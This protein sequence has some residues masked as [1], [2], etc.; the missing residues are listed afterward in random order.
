MAVMEYVIGAL[1]GGLD[2]F[3]CILFHGAFLPQRNLGKRYVP[4]VLAIWIFCCV[5]TN[6]PMNQYVKMVLSVTVYT[7]LSV[8]LLQ[9]AVPVHICLAIVYNIFN[10]SMDTLAIHGMCYLLGISYNAFVWHKLSYITL[11]TAEKLLVVFLMWILY[12][13]RKK[14][15]LGKQRSK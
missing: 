14:G 12:H 15:N 5:Y 7:V 1:W 13:F 10:A 11:I 8:L 2:L 6:I 3:G 9:G 4:K